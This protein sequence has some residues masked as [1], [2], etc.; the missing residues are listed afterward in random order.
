MLNQGC[1]QEKVE[2]ASS[3]L[4]LRYIRSCAPTGVDQIT[5][6][7][8]GDYPAS[9]ANLASIEADGRPSTVRSLPFDA[10]WYRVNVRTA[11]FLGVALA[12]AADNGQRFE[13]LVLPIEEPCLVLEDELAR[14]PGTAVALLGGRDL[15]LAGGLSKQIAVSDTQRVRVAEQGV[16]AAARLFAPRAFAKALAVGDETWI[17]GGAQS[18][19]EGSPAFDSFERYDATGKTLLGSGKLLRARMDAGAVTLADGSVLLAGGSAQVMGA[20]LDTLERVVGADEGQGKLSEARLPFGALQPRLLLRD[21]GLVVIAMR[22]E[23]EL[24][25]ALYDSLSDSLEA[26]PV[27]NQNLDPE[28]VVA[29]PGG[30]IAI[31]ESEGDETTSA[32]WLLG[33]RGDWE[34]LSGALTSFAGFAS[35]RA[36]ALRDGRILLTGA[37]AGANASR[38]IDP[39]T[40]A[41]RTRALP[42]LPDQLLLRDDG[43]VALL[44]DAALAVLRSDARSPYDNPAGTL[45]AEDGVLA[46]DAKD[47]W[48]L[49]GLALRALSD[50]ARLELAGLSFADVRVTVQASADAELLV[51]RVLGEERAIEIGAAEIGPA[52]CTT[53]HERGERVTIERVAERV[54]IASGKERQSCVLDGLGERIT[55]GVRVAEAG[56]EL[57]YLAVERL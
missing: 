29:L 11:Q 27:P 43:A 6:E 3:Q 1:R 53:T 47:H 18:A 2:K 33:E 52:L 16:S 4:Q 49:D 7:A 46:L 37:R 50:G 51:R 24:A 28:L 55:F 41:V 5:I 56:T 54:M 40:L 25:L 31:I 9:E 39:G 10:R 17:L 20:A 26:L 14:R 13:A 15:W 45:L 8:L 57:R 42:L 22:R 12:P 35:A 34:R 23:A 44:G 19:I 38:I 48:M 36:L 32:L 21:D 30:R